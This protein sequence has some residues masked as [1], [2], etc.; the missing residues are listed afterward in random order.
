MICNIK[1]TAKIECRSI[2]HIIS[3]LA[4]IVILL[5]SYSAFATSASAYS[6]STYIYDVQI[7]VNEDNTYDVSETIDV[8][9]NVQ[10]HGLFRDI[11]TGNFED[12]GYM[13]IKD[14][15]LK[16]WEFDTYSEE[17]NKVIRIGS[18]DETVIGRQ[19][20]E[21]NYRIKVYDDRNPEEDF[22]YLDVIPTGWETPIEEARVSIKLPKAIDENK[23]EVYSGYYGSTYKGSVDWTYEKETNEIIIKESRMMTGNGITVLCHLPEG[24][25]QGEGTYVWAKIMALVITCIVAGL[26]FLLWFMF[27]RDKKIVSTV[28]FY[29]PEGMNPAEVGYIIDRTVNKR[30]LVSLI[31]Y[32]ADKGYMSIEQIKNDNF[33]FVKLKDIDSKEKSFA[34]TL[35]N[36][37]FAG[38]DSVNIDDL[39][40]DFGDSYLAAYEQLSNYFMKKANRQVTVKSVVFQVLGVVFTMV[41]QVGTAAAAWWY[42][43]KT[44]QPLIA[45]ILAV[46]SVLVL[47]V[48]IFRTKKQY[49][50]KTASKLVGGT[51]SWLIKGM[52]SLA[53]GFVIAGLFGNLL[54]IVVFAGVN[55]AGELCI[56]FMTQRTKSSIEL[57][58]KILGL[59]NF[60]EKAELNRINILVEENPNYFYN[61]LPYAYVMGLTD[62]WAKNFEGISMVQPSWYHSN[63]VDI[64]DVWLFSRMMNHCNHSF[65]SNIHIPTGG[66][67]GVGGGGFSGG[68]GGFSGGGFG[69]G[70]GGSW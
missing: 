37:L 60:I 15:D 31:M 68:G 69:G 46:V 65:E 29:P 48:L 62:K 34:K 39:D 47:V 45:V 61:I 25:W 38:R 2:M 28:E 16:G 44:M 56:V 13:S 32:F 6:Y 26:A 55:F 21:I 24:Y 9:F 19:K 30:D 8:S 36:G 11:P 22:L 49:V 59:K 35:F 18:E 27:G 17:G 53:Y 64:F 51:I 70:G 40:E 58:G 20:Y 33:R 3:I 5:A 42:S 66:D 1:K 67:S 10:K 63:S 4:L 41:A 12:M 50:M 52:V 14:I 23:I 54:L 57:M 7:K 43:G